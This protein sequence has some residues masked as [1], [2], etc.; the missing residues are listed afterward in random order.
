MTAF[1]AL[2]RDNPRTVRTVCAVAL[3]CVALASLLIDTHHAHSWVEQHLPFFWSLFGFAA[4]VVIIGL[5]RWL[6][7]SGIQ[8]GPAIYGRDAACDEEE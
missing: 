7:R 6:G 8:T 4:S 5:T 3:A 2:L 1:I